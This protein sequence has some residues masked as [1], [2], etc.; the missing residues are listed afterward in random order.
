[1]HGCWTRVPGT[2]VQDTSSLS[3]RAKVET[4]DSPNTDDRVRA[5]RSQTCSHR[6]ALWWR[7]PDRPSDW[8]VFSWCDWPPLVVHR[9]ERPLHPRPN[10]P[11]AFD[12]EHSI[13]SFRIF[14]SQP[15]WK[16]SRIIHMLEHQDLMQYDRRRSVWYCSQHDYIQLV[17]RIN[18]PVVLWYLPCSPP[19]YWISLDRRR[20]ST[21]INGASHVHGSSSNQPHAPVGFL[22]EEKSVL[23]SDRVSSA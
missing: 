19:Y 6:I 3:N 12:A 13:N 8:R 7:W 2:S 23:N 11:P 17:C 14:H 5:S 18:L 10:H 15:T 4:T 21:S 16:S 9:D 22:H 1:M 20:L